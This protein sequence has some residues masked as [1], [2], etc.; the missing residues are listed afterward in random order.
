M[1][2]YHQATQQMGLYMMA[3]QQVHHSNYILNFHLSK[4]K[5]A[6][7]TIVLV[8]CIICCFRMGQISSC[9]Y[10]DAKEFPKVI[11]LLLLL[12]YQWFGL[13]EIRTFK[14]G[15]PS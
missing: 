5:K 4:E 10:Q 15:L 11:F 8:L 2:H 1:P 12:W 3:K 6:S 13:D 14:L 7:Q 9:S